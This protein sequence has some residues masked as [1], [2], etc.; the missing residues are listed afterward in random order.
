MRT[1]ELPLIV[2][3]EVAHV[4]QMDI[5][6]RRRGSYEGNCLS[7]SVN[8]TAWAEI[9][10]LGE[11]GFILRGRG[12]FVDA[13]SLSDGMRNAIV[14]WGVEQ[15]FLEKTEIFRLHYMDTE[16][17]EWRYMDCGSLNEATAEAEE[18]ED[19]DFRIESLSAFVATDSLANAA[20][21][22][23]K[24]D[25]SDMA[26]D[27]TLIAFAAT[28]DGIDGVWWA[29]TLDVGRLSAPR[30]GIFP[31]RIDGFSAQRADWRDF[32]VFEERRAYADTSGQTLSRKP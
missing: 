26:F 6:A 1:S 24:P 3:E 7:V 32:L 10:R 30:G 16:L 4:G 14:A 5:S 28:D 12:V 18:V 22:S 23:A 27:L 9:A 20:G 31:S 15:G 2:I 25:S 21:Q 11:E 13:L 19:V 29:E 17:D 8:P